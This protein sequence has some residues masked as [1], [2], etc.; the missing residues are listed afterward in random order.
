MR[1]GTSFPTLLILAWI[2]AR[3]SSGSS[4][5]TANTTFAGAPSGPSGSRRDGRVGRASLR[6]I[7]LPPARRLARGAQG[8]LRFHRA[9]VPL[10]GSP[11]VHG[12]AFQT[13]EVRSEEEHTS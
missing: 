8:H 2:A 5:S 4:D 1:P 9:Q 10:E 11:R 13:K 6:R 12:V 7:L 3:W